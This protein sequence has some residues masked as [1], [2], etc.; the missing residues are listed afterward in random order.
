MMA[1]TDGTAGSG[2]PEGTRATLGGRPIT[3][4][5]AAYLDDGTLAGSVLTM[6]R[7][8]KMLVSMGF[9]V[10]QAAQMCGTT[11]ARQRGLQSGRLVVG[12]IAD[13]VVL[14]EQLQ[15]VETW[16]DGERVYP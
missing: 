10:V 1:I 2:M 11:P 4:S 13:L 7:A 15:V 6:D 16:I 3:V 9:S 12:A 8:F 5:N 14:D